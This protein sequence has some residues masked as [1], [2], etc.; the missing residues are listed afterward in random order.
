MMEERFFDM[1]DDFLNLV[2][3]YLAGDIGPE[4]SKKLLA[5]LSANP[6]RTNVLC[7]NVWVDF[8]FRKKS[9]MLDDER[10]VPDYLTPGRQ[11]IVPEQEINFDDLVRWEQEVV[12]RQR[13]LKPRAPKKDCQPVQAKTSK[14][15]AKGMRIV[16]DRLRI[17]PLTTAI[18]LLFLLV[19]MAQYRFLRPDLSVDVSAFVPFAQVV[20]TI[21]AH[22]F[23]VTSSYKK[24]QNVGRGELALA[25]GLVKLR[26]NDGTELVLEGP[27]R[28][29]IAGEK[30]TFCTQGKISAHVPREGIGF[31]ITTPLGTV[32]DRGTDFVVDVSAKKTQVDVVTGTVDL[33][34]SSSISGLTLHQ[35]AAALIDE[36]NTTQQFQA[37]R[38][39]YIS[40]SLFATRQK[41]H[42]KQSRDRFRTLAD[43]WSAHPHLLARFD[44]SGLTGSRTDNLSVKG[45]QLLPT[46]TINNCR[47]T[48]GFYDGTAAV[49]F[50]EK[51]SF[52]FELP[53]AFRNLTLIASVRVDDLKDRTSVLVAGHDFYSAPG[54]LL[55]QILPDGTVQVQLTPGSNRAEQTCF[56]SQPFKWSCHWKTWSTVAVVLDADRKAISHYYDGRLVAEVPWK[57]PSPL[58]IGK[59]SLGN[60]QRSQFELNPLYLNGAM[61]DFQIYDKALS[62]AEIAQIK[63]TY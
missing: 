31:Q 8:W 32:V 27:S 49:L 19:G 48:K 53:G 11:A 12:P 7:E 22:W 13:R 38:T 18:V 30:N 56:S 42:T 21:N 14:P 41:E 35:G 16:S 9:Q 44:L 36:T 10:S 57:T 54:T 20:E 3:R 51:G 34:T 29:V 25:E 1:D 59:A 37:D 60:M 47:L 40:S 39:R 33:F 58:Y 63:K 52:D 61:D 4:E 17:I 15:L 23:D 24:G 6:E 43:T 46:G 2:D 55:W 5:I 26:F 45:K 28:F 50:G 62:S